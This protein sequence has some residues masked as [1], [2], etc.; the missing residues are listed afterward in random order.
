MSRGASQRNLSCVTHA[1]QDL[2]GQVIT[3]LLDRKHIRVKFV[4]PAGNVSWMNVSKSTIDP[5]KL[6][7]WTRQIMQRADV[8]PASN[9]RSRRNYLKPRKPIT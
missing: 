4:T 1:I 3:F 5:Y 2:G 6:K 8:T 7:G 9:R